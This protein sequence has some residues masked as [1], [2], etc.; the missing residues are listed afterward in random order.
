M[1]DFNQYDDYQAAHTYILEMFHVLW[2][3]DLTHKVIVG[4]A[5]L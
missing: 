5:K 1:Q 2:L 3:A 4:N